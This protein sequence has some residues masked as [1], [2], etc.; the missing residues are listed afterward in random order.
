VLSRELK[1]TA[2]KIQGGPKAARRAIS[3]LIKLGKSSKACDLY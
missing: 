3:L 2:D 1:V